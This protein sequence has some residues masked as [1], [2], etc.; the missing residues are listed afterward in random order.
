MG[1]EDQLPPSSE[2]PAEGKKDTLEDL[3]PLPDNLHITGGH[4]GDT[5]L[6]EGLINLTKEYLEKF[7][8][9]PKDLHITGSYTRPPDDTNVTKIEKQPGTL[10]KIRNFIKGL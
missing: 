6:P 5:Q 2:G 9:L 7:G 8:P 1:F 4:I 3:G 10:D